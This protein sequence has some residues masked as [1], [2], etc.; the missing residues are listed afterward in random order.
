V[1]FCHEM[2]SAVAK[3]SILCMDFGREPIIKMPNIKLFSEASYILR[4]KA[5]EM[6][7]H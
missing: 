4:E 6:T 5:L 2:K 3:Q 1:Y 7:S